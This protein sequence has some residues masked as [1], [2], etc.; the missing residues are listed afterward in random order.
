MRLLPKSPALRISA[1][2]HSVECIPSSEPLPRAMVADMS[3]GSRLKRKPAGQ[4][5]LLAIHAVVMCLRA[6]PLGIRKPIE[7]VAAGAPR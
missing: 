5:R 6:R 2:R 4:R 3:R 1:P 7:L